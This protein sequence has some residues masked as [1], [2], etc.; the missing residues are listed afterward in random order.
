MKRLLLTFLLYILAIYAL[1]SQNII[2]MNNGTSVNL[3]YETMTDTDV[4]LKKKGHVYG[5]GTNS[6]SNKMLLSIN[7]PLYRKKK[8]GFSLGAFYNYLEND[9]SVKDDLS[10]RL[11]NFYGSGHHVFGVNANSFFFTRM[12]KKYFVG[13]SNIEVEFTNYGFGKFT[14]FV[15]G[16]LMMQYTREKSL[17]IGVIGLINTT[18][19]FPIFPMLMY[20]TM[21]NEKIALEILPPR[22]NISCLLSDK[23]K[24]SVNVN[25]EGEHYY[26]KPQNDALPEICLH[27]RSIMKSGLGFE[28]KINKQF[29]IVANAGL[30]VTTASKLY[31]R[32]GNKSLI[33]FSENPTVYFNISFKYILNRK[34]S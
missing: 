5:K 23:S 14:G 31:K 6:N 29:T 18:S 4:E 27:S 11:Q 34:K 24:L 13:L 21:L 10:D 1:F 28:Q 16:V 15:A 32:N 30:K 22:F 2:D 3:S 19:P 12:F 7:H 20:R 33:E 8:I 26:I 17:G 9:F 25:V